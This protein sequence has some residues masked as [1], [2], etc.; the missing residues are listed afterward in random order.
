MKI[1]TDDHQRLNAKALTDAGAAEVILEDDL[2]VDRLASILTAVLSDPARLSAMSAAARSVA[3]P[4]AAQRL[5]DL[6]EATAGKAQ[7]QRP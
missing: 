7:P 4:Y 2:T 5:A 6:V 3:I 1:A